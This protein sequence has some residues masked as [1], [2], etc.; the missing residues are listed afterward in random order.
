MATSV[1]TY[2]LEVRGELGELAA[3]SF[4]AMR[5]FHRRGN[6]VLVG[7]VRDQAELTQLLERCSALGLTLVS[8]DASD[9]SGPARART[10]RRPEQ[11]R[12]SHSPG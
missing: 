1:R 11:A 2:R 7:P 10:A 4:P 5:I 9:D 8:V 6:S 12:G 3:R